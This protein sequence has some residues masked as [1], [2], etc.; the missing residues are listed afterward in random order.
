[1]VIDALLREPLHSL[2]SVFFIPARAKD[3]VNAR[4][5][6]DIAQTYHRMN[7]LILR[8]VLKEGIPVLRLFPYVV[9][10]LGYIRERTVDIEDDDF[11]CH[12]SLLTTCRCTPPRNYIDYL[13]DAFR[14]LFSIL[15]QCLHHRLCTSFGVNTQHRLR[16]GWANEQP[17]VVEHNVFDAIAL[18]DI[19]NRL[20]TNL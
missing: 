8:H 12:K 16:A 1:M 2:C 13:H 11:S 18:A 3:D 7:C 5:K 19:A 20:P 17:R 9:D 6:Q 15:Q 4:C 14:H 10:S